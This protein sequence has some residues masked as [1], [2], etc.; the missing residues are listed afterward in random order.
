MSSDSANRKGSIFQT[1]IVYLGGAWV[2]IEAF[3]FIIDKYRLDA[4]ILDVIIILVIFGL[5]ASIIHARFGSPLNKQ[6]IMLHTVNALVAIAVI[7]YQQINPSS[8]HPREIRLL[9]FQ[10]QQRSAAESIRSIAILP[11]SNYTGDEKKDFLS[12]GVHDALISEIG[13]VG[14]LRVISKTSVLPYVSTQKTIQDISKELNVD[15]IIEGS[16]IG[17]GESIRL[18]LKLINAFPEEMQLWTSTYELDMTNLIEVYGK[19]I[20]GIAKEI[21]IS[22]SPSEEQMIL[23]KRKVNPAAYEAYL[24]GKYSMGLLTKDGIEAAM[25][26]FNNAIQIDPEFAEAYGGLAGIWAFLKQ[27]D[28]VPTQQANPHIVS[29]LSK[30]IELDS[31]IADVHY[32]DA[33]KKVWTDANWTGGEKAFK[34]ALKINPN[35]SEAH[36]LYSNFLMGANRLDESRAEMDKALLL[37]PENPFIIVLNCVLLAIEGKHEEAVQLLVSIQENSPRHP[38]T[39]LGLIINYYML[40]NDQRCI[41]QIKIKLELEDHAEVI[42]E[43]SA[44]FESEGLK[45]ASLKAAQLLEEK[46]KGLLTSQSMQILYAIGGDPDK[47]LDWIELGLLRKDADKASFLINPIFDPYRGNERYRELE[48]ILKLEIENNASE[49]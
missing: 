44:T 19:M 12:A 26:H 23:Q 14:A 7:G 34:K 40:G 8:F 31:T 36:G 3:N 4:Q 9:H 16:M 21:N 37:D 35:F 43:V 6:S 48:R 30:A 10:N 46:D 18:Q 32:W 25:G 17:A 27:M 42:P 28:I 22:L 2:F 20:T 24:K 1:A 29:N 13:Q 45:A 38:L 11:F 5:P 49:L 47:T 41:E 33:I 39:N 15:A